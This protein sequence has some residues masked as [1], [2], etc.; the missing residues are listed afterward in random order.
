[1]LW[2]GIGGT[3]HGVDGGHE[4]LD[5]DLV[6]AWGGLLE[7]VDEVEVTADFV[8]EDAFHCACWYLNEWRFRCFLERISQIK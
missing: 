4:R 3:V 2:V 8:E 7:G 6:S 5:E 1:M